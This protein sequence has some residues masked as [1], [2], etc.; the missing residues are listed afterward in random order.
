MKFLKMTSLSDV[1]SLPH[2]NQANELWMESA[3]KRSSVLSSVC[4]SIVEEFLSF[5]FNNLKSCSD[6]KVLKNS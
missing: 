1:P 3:E 2:V 4:K 5:E 6:D